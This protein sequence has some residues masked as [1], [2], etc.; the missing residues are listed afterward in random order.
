M[1]EPIDWSKF[2]LRAAG[3]ALTGLMLAVL[4]AE[5]Q[6]LVAMLSIVAGVGLMV[7]LSVWEQRRADARAAA[8]TAPLNPAIPTPAP[9]DELLDSST[10][11]LDMHGRVR[12]VRTFSAPVY[13]GDAEYGMLM[14]C[15][16]S[17]LIDAH[18]EVHDLESD[19]RFGRIEQRAQRLAQRLGVPFQSGI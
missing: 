1:P 2:A 19:E 9:M 6:S 18:G 10:A 3:A 15:Y 7:A 8:A 5:F 14:P 11:L 16:C 12:E 17:V 13:K 4:W